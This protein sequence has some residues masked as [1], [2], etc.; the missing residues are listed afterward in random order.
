MTVEEQQQLIDVVMHKMAI[1]RGASTRRDFEVA[2]LTVD[3]LLARHRIGSATKATNA[4]RAAATRR[5]ESA[6]D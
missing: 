1:R 2:C 6:N 5:S 4:E 3:V